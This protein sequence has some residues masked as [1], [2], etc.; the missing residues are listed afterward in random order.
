MVRNRRRD[1]STY[2]TIGYIVSDY[3][4]CFSYHLLP[5]HTVS[6]LAFSLDD[7]VWKR[8]RAGLVGH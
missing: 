8:D 6:P 4:V 1:E 7:V 3:V 5:T 2:I